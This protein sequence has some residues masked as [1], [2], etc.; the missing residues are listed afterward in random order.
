MT[1]ASTA[2][3]VR[4]LIEPFDCIVPPANY[5]HVGCPTCGNIAAVRPNDSERLPWCVHRPGKFCWGDPRPT[6]E[7]EAEPWTRMVPICVQR[8]EP[9]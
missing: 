9:S 1:V 3:P 6:T 8:R 4:A 2:Q 5:V 7:R